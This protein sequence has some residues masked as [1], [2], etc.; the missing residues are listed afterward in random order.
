MH[1]K[2]RLIT[3]KVKAK[4]PFNNCL[5]STTRISLYC[6]ENWGWQDR[7]NAWILQFW[8]QRFDNIWLWFL[9]LPKS[10]WHF[11]LIFCCYWVTHVFQFMAYASFLSLFAVNLGVLGDANGNKT[12]FSQWQNP[13]RC[14]ASNL[15]RFFRPFFSEKVRWRNCRDLRMKSWQMSLYMC[16]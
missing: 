6:R 10:S 4:E 15:L 13:L 12:S 2:L 11:R 8:T 7:E 16:F 14:C 1:S 5:S 3:L 9:F